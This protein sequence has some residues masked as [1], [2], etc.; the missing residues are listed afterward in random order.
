MTGNTV[1]DA[2]RIV[3]EMRKQR[4]VFEISSKAERLMLVTAHRRESIGCPIDNICRAVQ[5]LVHEYSDLRVLWP[6]HPNPNV[7]EPIRRIL[8]HETRI[9]LVSPMEYDEF[10]GSMNEFELGPD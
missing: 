9:Q 3:L 10:V 7:S 5:Q 1:I 8:S 4:E 6:V 2:L